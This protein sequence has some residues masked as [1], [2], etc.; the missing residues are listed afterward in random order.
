MEHAYLLAFIKNNRLTLVFSDTESATY[1]LAEKHKDGN[2][3]AYGL[4]I[5]DKG[6][7]FLSSV[8]GRKQFKL[9]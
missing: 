9:K 5:V 4:F 3:S 2:V 8:E 1:R 7:I 6:N